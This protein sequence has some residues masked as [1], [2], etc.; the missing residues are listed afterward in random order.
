MMVLKLKVVVTSTSDG[1]AVNKG[2]SW[3]RPDATQ[4]GYGAD[5]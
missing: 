5:D 3:S 4:E 1:T 2:S